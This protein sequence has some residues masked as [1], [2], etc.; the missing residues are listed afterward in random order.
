M[1]AAHLSETRMRA[2]VQQA[3][4]AA[5]KHEVAADKLRARLAD[6][7]AAQERRAKRNA[8]AYARAKRALAAS[9]GQLLHGAL[10]ALPLTYCHQLCRCQRYSIHSL[11]PMWQRRIQGL[12]QC[13]HMRVSVSSLAA[14]A[15]DRKP[16]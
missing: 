12:G 16:G 15:Q 14:A 9:R 7:V 1:R 10:T 6:D 8:D 2:V 4:R 11:Y 3:E 13:R 5:R